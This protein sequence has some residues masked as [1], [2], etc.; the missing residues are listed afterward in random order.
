MSQCKL[1]NTEMDI[2]KI[3]PVSNQFK[4]KFL[5]YKDCGF[6]PLRDKNIKRVVQQKLLYG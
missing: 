6:S 4:K 3:C 5:C 1:L 2:N